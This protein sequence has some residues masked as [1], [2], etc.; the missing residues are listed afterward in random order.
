MSHPQ[1]L[2]DPR[3]KFDIELNLQGVRC[4]F[5][6]DNAS[7]LTSGAR[8]SEPQQSEDEVTRL[9]QEV[10][11]LELKNE[12]LL[13]ML[14]VKELDLQKAKQLKKEIEDL[15]NPALPPMS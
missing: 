6:W 7:W 1:P 5:D 15:V 3:P 8:Q 10:K 9:K 4:V 2:L 11:N 14:T 12:I 13:D